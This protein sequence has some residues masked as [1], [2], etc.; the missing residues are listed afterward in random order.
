ML[1]IVRVL[2]MWCGNVQ[3][4]VVVEMTFA[5]KLREY[6]GDR[7]GHCKT[8]DTSGKASFVVGNE[9]WED[10]CDALQGLVKGIYY[11]KYMGGTEV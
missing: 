9:F 6:L 3:H 4:R 11:H 10:H 1:L 8:V 5:C 2:A 7:H